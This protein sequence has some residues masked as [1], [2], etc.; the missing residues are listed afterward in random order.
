M[1]PFFAKSSSK[2]FIEILFRAILITFFDM[3]QKFQQTKPYPD[4]VWVAAV[5]LLLVPY[6]ADMTFSVMQ[7][8]LSF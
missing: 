2:Y 8:N 4:N 1:I 6:D 7:T 5:Y 3:S